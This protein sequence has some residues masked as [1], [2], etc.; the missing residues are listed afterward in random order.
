MGLPFCVELTEVKTKETEQHLKQR[1]PGFLK[2]KIISPRIGCQL[3]HRPD[4]Q[5]HRSPVLETR[6]V[7][8]W[9]YLRPKSEKSGQ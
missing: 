4:T 5:P 6:A 1:H 3:G 8:A 2:L 7:A 9:I